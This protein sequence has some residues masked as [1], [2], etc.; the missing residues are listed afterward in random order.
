MPSPPP[1]TPRQRE[2]FATSVTILPDGA[3]ADASASPRLCGESPADDFVSSCLRGE[4]DR[5][6]NEPIAP[7]A[8]NSQPLSAPKLADSTPSPAHTP[9]RNEPIRAGN[10]LRRGTDCVGGDENVPI[11]TCPHLSLFR[12]AYRP[13]PPPWPPKPPPPEL[14]PPP[15]LPPRDIDPPE[16]DRLIPLVPGDEKL[17]PPPL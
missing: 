10:L 4:I 11:R 5:L 7:A 9:L 17:C 15:K 8:R 1:T 13:R 2:F 12:S 6:R 16:K 14:L 3:P